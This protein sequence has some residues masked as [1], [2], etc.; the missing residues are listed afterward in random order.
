MPQMHQFDKN[1][2]GLRLPTWIRIFIKGLNSINIH[3][4]YINELLKWKYGL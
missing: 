4:T 2:Y 3:Q 1:V